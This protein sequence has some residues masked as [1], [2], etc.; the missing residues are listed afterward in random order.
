LLDA[1]T[2]RL[3]GSLEKR[4]DK[5]ESAIPGNWHLVRQSTPGLAGDYGIEKETIIS[6]IKEATSKKIRCCSAGEVAA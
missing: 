4:S 3:L 2:D 6:E 1:I 5:I